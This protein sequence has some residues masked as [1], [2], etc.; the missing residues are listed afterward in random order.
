MVAKYAAE[1]EKLRQDHFARQ[2]RKTYLRY[3]DAVSNGTDIDWAGYEI[4]EPKKLGITVFDDVNLEDLLGFMDWTPFFQAWELHGRY[5][6]LLDDEVVGEEARKLLK[7]AQVLLNRIVKDK[8]LQ[9]KG[10]VGLF[11]ANRSGGDDI[12]LFTDASRSEELATFHCLRQQ[13]KKGAGAFNQ[14]LADFIAPAQAGVDYIGTFALTTGIG[15]D[16]LVAEFEADHD[17]YNSIM[18]K[19]LADRLAEAFA[20]YLHHKVRTE[21]WGY[22]LDEKLE[23]DQLIREKYRG[24]RPAPGYPACP[25]HTEKGILFDL[26]EATSRT[27]ITL[28]E[29]FAML[30]TAA[31]SGF[32]FAHP[33]SRY[34]GLGKIGEDQVMAYA[35]RKGMSKSA[36][37][38]W[39]G[40]NLNYEPNRDKAAD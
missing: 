13:H 30:P 1:Y 17:D 12:A 36:A 28:T 27:G 6:K 40:P 19:A 2:S 16:A 33:E 22:A 5:P 11:P 9:A 23:N 18:A 8:L 38:R 34:F 26:L 25:D 37:E 39:L 3:E 35:E 20:E 4:P 14:S 31:V 7:D 15:L 29:S 32:Y 10:V 24:I 21:I